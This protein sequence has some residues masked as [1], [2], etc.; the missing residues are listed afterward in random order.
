MNALAETVGQLRS[1]CGEA[2]PEHSFTQLTIN[3][4][5]HPLIKRFHKTDEEK[6]AL[7]ILPQPEWDDWLDCTDP[8]YARSFLRPYPAEQMRGREFPVPPR[9]KRTRASHTGARCA[10]ELAMN[11]ELNRSPARGRSGVHGQQALYA[12]RRCGE[13]ARRVGCA[14]RAVGALARM[15]AVC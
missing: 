15:K 9:A 7:V 8:E 5:E 1:C 6:R 11:E 4:D 2:G 14:E 10:D 12:S 13:D 3:A